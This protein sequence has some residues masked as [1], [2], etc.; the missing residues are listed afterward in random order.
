MNHN[1][2]DELAKLLITLTFMEVVKIPQQRENIL[3][4]LDDT[5]SRIEAIVIN[6]RKQ[7]NITSIRSR[8]KVPQFYISIENHDFTFFHLCELTDSF[9][10]FNISFI[11]RENNQKVDSLE[12]D[13]SLFI[14]MIL[15]IKLLFM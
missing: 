3:K 4:I 7:Q 2:V 10:S 14:Q 11:P 5:N 8:S 15:V 6:T 1:L 13:A 9:N 12:V